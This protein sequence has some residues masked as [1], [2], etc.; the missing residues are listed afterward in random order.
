MTAEDW[1]CSEYKPLRAHDVDNL[2]K[3]Q[4]TQGNTPVNQKYNEEVRQLLKTLLP[5][6][7][8]FNSP[9]RGI[10]RGPG[11]AY[12]KMYASVVHTDFPVDIDTYRKTNLWLGCDEQVNHFEETDA[13]SYYIINLWRPVLPM[14]GPVRS[15]PL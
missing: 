7:T 8:E 3:V 14:Q 6:A 12:E 13:A 15:T 5:N 2:A 1:C 4:F 9:V 10:Q 11:S